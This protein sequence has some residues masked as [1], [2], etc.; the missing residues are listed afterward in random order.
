MMNDF[1]G[2]L[3]NENCM[4]LT[5][6]KVIGLFFQKWASLIVNLVIGCW[7]E[8]GVRCFPLYRCNFLTFQR[9][10]FTYLLFYEIGLYYYWLVWT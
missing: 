1:G 6:K 9:I 4:G 10:S 8:K 3:V 5:E 2:C 7:H